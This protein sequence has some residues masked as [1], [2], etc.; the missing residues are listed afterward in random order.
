MFPTLARQVCLFSYNKDG[1]VTPVCETRT[2]VCVHDPTLT[3][4][5]GFLHFQVCGPS[6]NAGF[7]FSLQW[8]RCLGCATL[9][10]PF[11][12][13]EIHKGA[14]NRHREQLK[15][16]GTDGGRELWAWG[17]EGRS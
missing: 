13:S 5:F 17:S 1:C 12:L 14:V 3:P 10:S 15:L 7:S 8:G 11:K 4:S 9:R 16:S 6:F 2:R